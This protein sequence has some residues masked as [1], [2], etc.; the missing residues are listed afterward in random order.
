MGETKRNVGTR[1]NEHNDPKGIS[2]PS[3][4]LKSNSMHVFKWSVLRF[5][6]RHFF[7]RCILEALYIS[8]EKPVL[9]NKVDHKSLSLFRNGIT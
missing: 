2:E 3:K 4:H 9:S 1:W 7:R 6:P 5:A 8:L